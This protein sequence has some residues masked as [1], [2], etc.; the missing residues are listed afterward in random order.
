MARFASRRDFLPICL[1][2]TSISLSNCSVH[3]MCYHSLFLILVLQDV[4]ELD[5]EDPALDGGQDHIRDYHYIFTVVGPPT[6]CLSASS[7]KR[8]SF[9]ISWKLLPS[10]LTF[11][12]VRVCVRACGRFFLFCNQPLHFLFYD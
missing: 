12:R 5:F 11:H 9:N 2:G 8:I 4:I 3:L 10:W 6:S 1:R 7:S